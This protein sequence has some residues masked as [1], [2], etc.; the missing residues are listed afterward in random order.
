MLD[1]KILR[2]N[3]DLIKKALKD[4]NTDLNLEEIL[5]LDNQRKN[6]IQEIEKLKA[7]KNKITDE[8]AILKKEKKDAKDKIIEVTE[9]NKEINEIDKYLPEIEEKF[10]ALLLLIPNIPDKDVPVGKDP[11][12]NIEVKRVGQPPEFSFNPLPHWDIG[13]TLEIIDFERAVKLSSS[14]FSIYKKMGAML[15]RALINFMLD[16]HIK[17]GYTEIS[18]PYLVNSKSMQGSGQLPRF[19]EELYKCKDDDLYLIPTAEVTLL[20]MHKDEVLEEA[21]LP[22]YY[23]SYSACFRREAGSYGKDVRGLIRQHQFDKVEIFQFTHP[24]KSFNEIETMVLEAEEIL[25]KLNLHYRVIMLCTGDLGFASAKTYDLE[26]WMPGLNAFKEISSCSNCTDFQ[27]R[28]ANIK[29]KRK[30]KLEFVHTLNGSGLAVGRTLA[31]ILENYQMANGDVYI[32]EV[33]RPYLG[34]VEKISVEK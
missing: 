23:V 10:K 20:N 18:S 25:K 11:T 17:N 19:A 9:L 1:L 4:R 12:G 29:F 13:E 32:P 14:R 24:E 3:T 26:V 16:I 28:R 21:K 5:S 22:L 31:A 2:E 30:G 34:G 15:E 8:I 33:L 27:A 6:K 7:K